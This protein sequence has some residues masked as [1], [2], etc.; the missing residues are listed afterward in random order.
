MP[1][2]ACP[3]MGC[4]PILLGSA[5]C[6]RRPAKLS[7]SATF[8]DVFAPGYRGLPR[9]KCASGVHSPL[10]ISPCDIDNQ[11]ICANVIKLRDD[12]LSCHAR[13]PEKRG[14]PDI[15]AAV[16]NQNS[17]C[18]YGCPYLN[19]LP[20]KTTFLHPSVNLCQANGFS[21]D[22]PTAVGH[23]Q[24]LQRSAA[25]L[26]GPSTCENAAHLIDGSLTLASTLQTGRRQR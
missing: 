7:D 25:N 22:K 10:M 20:G 18:P 4:A 21:Y 5:T 16:P 26:D 15:L 17:S 8:R 3:T 23:R 12:P 14:N 2:S 24:F 11:S 1:A 6:A 9:L 13:C 19:A